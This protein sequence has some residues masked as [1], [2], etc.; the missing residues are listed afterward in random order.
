MHRTR[1]L[2]GLLTLLLALL[3]AWMLWK[4][5]GAAQDHPGLHVR[6]DFRDARG[7]RAGADV[8]Y[9][10][11]TVGT[12]TNVQVAGD[13]TKAV[14]ALVLDDAGAEQACVNSAFWIVSP[15]FSGL[16]SGASGLDTL[17]RDT[18]VAFLTPG[19]RGSQLLPGSLLAGAERPP[20]TIEPDAM[21]PIA[22]GDLLM[23]LLVPENHGL[24]AGSPVVFRGTQTG[25]VRSVQLAQDGRYVEVVLRIGNRHRHTVTDQSEFW[26]ARPYVS[27]ALLS[28]FTVADVAS[29]VSPFVSYVSEPGKGSP[30]EDG[31]RAAAS[32][33]RPDL[34]ASE[35]P[36]DALVQP[37]QTP[38][39]PGD[40]LV[41]VRIAYA[42][43]EQDSMSADDPVQ[44]DGTGVLY[45]DSSGR[46]V[47]LTTRSAVDGSYITSDVFGGE[48]DI[49]KEQIKV[50]LRN[51]PVLRAHRVWVA[52]DGLDLAAL[53]L[54]EAPPTLVGTPAELLSFAESAAAETGEVRAVRSDGQPLA[55]GTLGGETSLLPEYRGGVL[56]LDGKVTSLL[57]QTGARKNTSPSPIRL[58]SVPED[59]RPRP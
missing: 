15:R 31:Y 41:L 54:D 44:S 24:R 18:Y 57:G 17:V 58:S 13:G 2:I 30:V 43:V 5:L 34:D 47:V 21:E 20:A 40:P 23:S 55:K 50:V 25:D 27:G 26:V 9:R 59:L 36:S 29:L 38:V 33:V 35:V 19:E 11:V 8:R 39:V 28:G 49:A 53:V 56:V 6:L 48:P 51:G 10:G 1:Y 46:A 7:L 16:A 22:H 45:L 37:V 42:A 14:V 12:V 4:M 52:P 3:G 32:A